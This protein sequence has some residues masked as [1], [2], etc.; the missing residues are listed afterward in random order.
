MSGDF[1]NIVDTWTGMKT[2]ASIFMWVSNLNIG[3]QSLSFF[4]WVPGEPTN[5][6]GGVELKPANNYNWNDAP[7]SWDRY[8]VC[9]KVC[10]YLCCTRKDGS[11]KL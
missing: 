9:K 10:V 3:P 7:D 5:N 4:S 8:F 11:Q 2:I 6:D 1:C